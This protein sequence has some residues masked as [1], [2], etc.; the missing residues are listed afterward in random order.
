MVIEAYMKSQGQGHIKVDGI[1]P[2]T[3]TLVSTT[4]EEEFELRFCNELFQVN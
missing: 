3:G 2:Q 4:K 1:N